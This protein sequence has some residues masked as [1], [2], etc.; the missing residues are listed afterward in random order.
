MN[1]GREMFMR[2]VGELRSEL[3][4]IKATLARMQAAG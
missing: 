3:A 2:E 4:K 1:A